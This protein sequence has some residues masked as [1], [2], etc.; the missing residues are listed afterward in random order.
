MNKLLLVGAG[1]LLAIFL[2]PVLHTP[3]R[4]ATAENEAVANRAT[5]VIEAIRRYRAECEEWP[6]AD[7]IELVKA[8]RGD[9]PQE[10]VFLDLPPE[11]PAV[12]DQ[13]ELVDP[14]GTPLRITIDTKTDKPRVRSAGPNRLFE[15][16]NSRGDDY[17]SAAKSGGIPGLPF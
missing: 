1:V 16:A 14:W 3:R 13:G 17:V 15:E 7:H 12:T 4:I 6:P 2:F 9:N 5:A 11:S 8:L 10:T